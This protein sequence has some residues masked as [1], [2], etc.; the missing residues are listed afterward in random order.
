MKK[1]T[2]FED[3]FNKLIKDYGKKEVEISI[4]Q[5]GLN[6]SNFITIIDHVII[7]PLKESDAKNWNVKDKKVG[8]IVLQRKSE[9]KY[10]TRVKIPFSLGFNTMSAVFLKNGVTIKTFNIE[11]NIKKYPVN[12]KRLA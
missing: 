4:K 5:N 3:I 6:I 1:L 12:K 8:L 2:T 7:K 10:Y 11:F 9:E